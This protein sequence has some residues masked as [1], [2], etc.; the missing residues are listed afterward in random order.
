[1]NEWKLKKTKRERSIWTSP[2][3]W[4]EKLWNI[5]VTLIPIV[6]GAFRSIPKGLIREVEKLEIRGRTETIQTTELLR[7][8]RILRRVLEIWGDFLL[9]I[10]HLSPHNE[11]VYLPYIAVATNTS[12]REGEEPLRITE[13]NTI[14][15]LYPYSVLTN[16]IFLSTNSLSI[17]YTFSWEYNY[18]LTY[19]GLPFI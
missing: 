8:T 2:R 17:V 7:S 6:I 16:P 14:V 11:L 3:N 13:A 1:M 10:T 19:R 18:Y 15:G 5:R 4:K 12:S 9:G